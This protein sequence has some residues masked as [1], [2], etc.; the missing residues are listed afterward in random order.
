MTA[1]GEHVAPRPPP[2]FST[3]Y[4][5]V[6]RLVR[7]RHSRCSSPRSLLSIIG[8][9]SRSARGRDGRVSPRLSAPIV[10]QSFE[11]SGGHCHQRKATLQKAQRSSAPDAARNRL[12]SPTA[13]T[14]DCSPLGPSSPSSLASERECAKRT[15][16]SGGRGGG[17]GAKME[18]AR[19]VPRQVRRAPLFGPRAPFDRDVSPFTAPPQQALRLGT[20]S[21]SHP[22]RSTCW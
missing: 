12:S 2:P 11:I 7:G 4:N 8:E 5:M 15:G 10:R 21:E 18:N 3:A 20:A 9:S 19:G 1:P 16:A 6:H 13:A 14:A 22:G 17:E